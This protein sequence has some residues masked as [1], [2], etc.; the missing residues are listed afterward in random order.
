MRT[1]TTTLLAAQK[2]ASRRPYVKVEAANTRAGVVNLQWTR[3]YTGS[4]V[5]SVHAATM[6]ADGS[7]IRLY[8]TLAGDNRKLY[9]QRVTNPGPGS[10]F[11]QWNYLSIYGIM[12]VAACSLGAEV[13][14]FWVKTTGEIDRIKST[15][16]G[17]TWQ[18]VD[19]PG[20]APS[21]A[22]TQMAAAYNP[23]RKDEP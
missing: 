15:D 2:A 5:D 11:T 17:A 21:G 14:L 8:A 3:L 9:R 1:L 4:E 13:S 7:L 10:D 19:Y 20:Y 18:A 6:P 12:A 23:N 16:N 22:V